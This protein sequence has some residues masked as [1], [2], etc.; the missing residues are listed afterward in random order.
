VEILIVNKKLLSLLT[1][2]FASGIALYPFILLE[3]KAQLADSTLLNHE[4]IHLRQQLELGIIPFYL[5]Y[6]SHYLL[7]RA[8]GLSALNAYYANVFEVEAY[9][10][11][12]NTEYLQSRPFW[13]CFRKVKLPK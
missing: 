4:R 7:L 11:E 2:N 6:L 1:R 8:K 9:A 5:I 10:Q 12:K 13:A 3:D